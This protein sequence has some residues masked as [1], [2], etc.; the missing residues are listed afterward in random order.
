MQVYSPQSPSQDLI[1][2][3]ETLEPGTT[4]RNCLLPFT[5][6]PPKSEGG[7]RDPPLDGSHT[8]PELYDWH[9][10]NNPDHP[11]F[12]FEDKAQEDG[13]RRLTF[14][15]LVP[16][17]HRAGQMIL[18]SAGVPSIHSPEFA[19]MGPVGIVAV[20]GKSCA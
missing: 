5:P 10:E 1:M 7:F 18:K 19:R 6:R 14:Q 2:A 11:A 12:V 15:Q 13:L 4:A 16:A 20:T 8:L 3:L 9:Y 17:I